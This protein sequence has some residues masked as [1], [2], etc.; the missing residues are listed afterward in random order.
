MAFK[1]IHQKLFLVL[2]HSILDIYGFM[3]LQFSLVENFSQ[4][5]RNKHYIMHAYL[6][7]VKSHFS[8]TPCKHVFNLSQLSLLRKV[9][10]SLNAVHQHAIIA[11]IFI[12]Q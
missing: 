11:N 1:L 3:E 6:P 12:L 10:S 4:W 5:K 7:I 9:R 2:L 8:K